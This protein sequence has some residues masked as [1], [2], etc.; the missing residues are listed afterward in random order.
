VLIAVAVYTVL[1]FL[2]VHPLSVT[3]QVQLGGQQQHGDIMQL[4]FQYYTQLKLVGV[5]AAAADDDD[6]LTDLF[7]GDAG[8]GLLLESVAA[9]CSSGAYQFGLPG[10][11]RPF[12][13]VEGLHASCINRVGAC[14]EIY[15][16]GPLGEGIACWLGM[17][18]AYI[19]LCKGNAVQE[20]EC[21]EATVTT[22]ASTH[23]EKGNSR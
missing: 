15:R 9:A 6:L 2:Q 14:G 8:D 23:V 19:K 1:A 21:G 20:C 7:L 17:L 13:C 18:Q 12:R 11:P 22:I 5:A 16:N 4:S 3:F 10:R